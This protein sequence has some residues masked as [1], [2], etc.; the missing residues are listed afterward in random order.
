MVRQLLIPSV[1]CY[2]DSILCI[3]TKAPFC[4]TPPFPSSYPHIQECGHVLPP[5]LQYRRRGPRPSHRLQPPV[6]LPREFQQDRHNGLL[7]RWHVLRDARMHFGRSLQ[8]RRLRGWHERVG[9]WQRAGARCLRCCCCQEQGPS[10]RSHCARR[11]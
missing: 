9:A 5:L 2:L 4:P 7:Q 11:R 3:I 1:S 6:R 8:G 10:P